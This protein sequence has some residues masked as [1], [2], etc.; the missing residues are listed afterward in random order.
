MSGDT[1]PDASGPVG[2]LHGWLQIIKPRLQCDAPAASAKLLETAL[3]WCLPPAVFVFF[4]FFFLD[5]GSF[6]YFM[7]PDT[8]YQHNCYVF[9]TES[10][11]I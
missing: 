3:W 5:P 10:C 2:D 1:F 7:S 8:Y 6:F 4:L 11:I 9:Y